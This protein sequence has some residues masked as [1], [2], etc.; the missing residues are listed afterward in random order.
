[1]GSGREPSFGYFGE[2]S[3]GTSAFWMRRW[4]P[5]PNLSLLRRPTSG[6]FSFWRNNTSY[7]RTT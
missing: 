6:R 4:Q 7:Q 5:F 2:E 3:R 1:M